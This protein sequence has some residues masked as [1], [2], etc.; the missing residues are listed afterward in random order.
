V[1]A[2]EAA[3]LA[4]NNHRDIAHDAQVGRSTFA[5]TFGAAGSRA[6]F[7]GLLF[8]AFLLAAVLAAVERAPALLLPCLLLPSAFKLRRDFFSCAPGLAFNDV[9]FRTFVMGLQFSILLAAGAIL[10]RASASW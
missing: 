6:M 4:V 7:V 3:A 10:D 2:L 1:G 5:V 8:G 9:L